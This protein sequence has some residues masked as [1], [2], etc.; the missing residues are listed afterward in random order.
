M[1][2]RG[3][4]VRR[5]STHAAACWT[6]TPCA[7]HTRHV[8]DTPAMCPTHT[9]C[10]R[11]TRHVPDTHAMCP[12]HPTPRARQPH[13]TAAGA[14]RPGRAPGQPPAAPSRAPAPVLR[15]DSSAASAA[16]SPLTPA[17]RPWRATASTVSHVIWRQCEMTSFRGLSRAHE[18]PAPGGGAHEQ[19]RDHRS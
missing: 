17:P 5:P 9:P 12:T 16:P 1:V 15:S 8:P 2:G 18:A 3:M 4:Q 19:L 6:H 10:A 11:H 13:P 14:P 7:R